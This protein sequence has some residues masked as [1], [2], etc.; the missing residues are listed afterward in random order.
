MNSQTTVDI[1]RPLLLLAWLSALLGG[2]PLWPHLQL[3]VQVL[4]PLALVAGIWAERR[5]RV[6][7]GGYWGSVIVVLVFLAYA[8]QVRITYL[9]DPVTSLAVS[10]GQLRTVFNWSLL[11]PVVSLVLMVLFFLILPRTQSPLMHFLNPGG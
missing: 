4:L 5:G 3:P 7:L 2:I 1:R 11:L 6:L 8:L 10:S 9:V